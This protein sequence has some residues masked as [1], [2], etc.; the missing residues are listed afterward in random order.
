MIKNNKGFV[1]TEVLILSTVIIGVLTLMYVQF[2]NIN[3]GYQYSFKYDTVEG[4]YLANNIVNYINDGNYDKLIELLNNNPKGYIDIT[5]CNIENSNLIS[6]CSSLFQKSEIEKIIFTEENLTKLKQNMSD[7]END[8]KNY[9]NQIKVTNEQNDYRIIIKYKNGTFSSMRFNKENS[10]VEDGLIAYLDG[11]NNT[12][13]GHST[14]T[15]IWKDLSNHG[16]DATLY[17]SPTWNNN[18]LTF[19]GKTN[20]GRLENTTNMTYENGVKLETRVKTISLVGPTYQEFFGNWEGAGI[21]IAYYNTNQYSSN[22]HANSAWFTALIDDNISNLDEY[23]TITTTYN[24]SEQK[25]YINGIL[26]KTENRGNNVIITPSPAPFAIGGNPSPTGMN[27]YNNV[28][29]QNV[30]IYDRALTENEVLRNYQ[31]DLARY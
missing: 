21:G 26:V 15:A 13:F 5:E 16:N 27:A 28:E 19:D 9:I 22:M 11:I 4:M 20:Y 12:G 14:E 3:R 7:L 18:S 30:L 25:L 17:N 2:K 10:Y 6:Y 29:F 24:N 31:V 23:Y 1:I 8:F